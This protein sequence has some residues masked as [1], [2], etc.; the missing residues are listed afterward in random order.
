MLTAG[1]RVLVRSGLLARPEY[2]ARLAAALRKWD[3]TPAACL[4]AQAATNPD[5]TFVVDERGTLTYGE[6]D[7][8][9]NAI[10]NG[11][12]A[13]GVRAGDQLGLMCRNHRGFIEGL[14]AGSKLGATILLLNTDFAGPQLADVLER[15]Q[16]AAI[17]H[18][19]EFGDVP[20]LASAAVPSFLGWTERAPGTTELPT[21]E[22]LIGT[23]DSRAPE[24]PEAPGR[25]IILSSGTTGTPK[26][27][28][29]AGSTPL[30]P[31]VALLDRI[32]LRA[33]ETHV[34]GSPMFHGWG[35][36]HLGLGLL[37]G[38]TVVLRRRFDPELTLEAIDAH[39]AAS[40]PMVPVMLQRVM[41]LDPAIR[42]QYDV[43]SLRTIPLGGSALPAGLAVEAMDALGDVVYNL[44]GST[45]VALATAATPRDLR[46]APG[47]AGRPLAGTKVKILGADDREVPRGK[48]GRVFVGSPLRSDGYSGGGA[49]EEVRGLLSSGDL[50]HLDARGRLTIDGRE[51]DMIV[52]G[53]ENVYPGEVED[54]L[55]VH[56]AIADA[57]VVGIEDARFGQRLA[58]FVVCSPGSTLTSDAVRAHVRAS[59]ARY[60]VPRDVTFLEELPR[61]PT[62]KVLKRELQLL[63]LPQVKGAVPA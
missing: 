60:K 59:L 21:L 40:A 62:G 22:E 35:F 20:G 7:Q 6:V 19:E 43:S 50:G 41:A 12:T 37:L 57:A 18:D 47:T 10:A 44:Y 55:A 5:R 49:K 48:T 27:V 53:G 24:P 16:P 63:A 46:E 3:R 14:L 15:E 56:P 4:V 8:R 11:L 38:S 34:I 9:T 52:S 42:A 23:N 26:G 61:N 31:L 29:R 13:A 17:M 25:V 45:E 33:R 51:D 2:P 32:P 28:R 54:L 58:A 39:R 36:L 1:A 30:V